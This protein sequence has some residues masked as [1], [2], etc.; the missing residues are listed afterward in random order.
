[1]LFM[2]PDRGNNVRVCILELFSPFLLEFLVVFQAL[3][4]YCRLQTMRLTTLTLQINV[5]WTLL[6]YKNTTLI[7]GSAP[8]N[9]CIKL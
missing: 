3:C 9:R 2:C 6:M 7:Y 8:F 5:A 4:V 1:M